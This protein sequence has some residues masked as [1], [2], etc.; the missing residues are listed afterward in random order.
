MTWLTDDILVKVDRASMK[1]SIEVRNPYLDVNLASY[2]A[3]IPVGL[4]MKGLK[5]KYILKESLRNVLPGF[6][7]N[8]KKSGFNAPVSSWI[9][10]FGGDEFKA[11]T[12]YVFEKKI[13]TGLN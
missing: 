4:K 5:T 12:K 3:S 8:K 6:I 10:P 7:L 11:F 2:C 13:A 9:E 1:N